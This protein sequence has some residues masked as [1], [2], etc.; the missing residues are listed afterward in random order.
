MMTEA[1]TVA[2]Q[3]QA[4]DTRTTAQPAEARGKRKNSLLEL[5]ETR[6]LPTS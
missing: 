5:L 6:V 2:I 1:E 3:L 4:R